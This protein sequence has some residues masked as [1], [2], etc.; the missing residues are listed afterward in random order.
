MEILDFYFFA[1]SVRN[2]KKG[3]GEENMGFNGFYIIQNESIK[4]KKGKK[5][6]KSKKNRS[7]A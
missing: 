5:E 1:I 3:C 2:G 6:N 4:K 7:M